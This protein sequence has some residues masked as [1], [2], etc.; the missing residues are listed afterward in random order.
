MNRLISL[1][2][3]WPFRP[4]CAPPRHTLLCR[5]TAPLHAALEGGC[6]HEHPHR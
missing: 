2:R 3:A 5:L 1:Y 4:H 6:Y